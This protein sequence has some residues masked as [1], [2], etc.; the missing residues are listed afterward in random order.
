VWWREGGLSLL[1]L[2]IP[3]ALEVLCVRVCIDEIMCIPSDLKAIRPQ[4]PRSRSSTDFD[5]YLIGPICALV[6]KK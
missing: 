3:Y 1:L 5:R 4:K 6:L 2:E